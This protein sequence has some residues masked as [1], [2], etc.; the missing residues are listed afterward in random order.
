[1]TTQAQ[2]PG[3]TTTAGEVLALVLP[4]FDKGLRAHGVTKQGH[5]R[6]PLYVPAGRPLI[7]WPNQQEVTVGGRRDVR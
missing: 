7:A 1:M 6:H 4:G 3:L 2:I 5:P